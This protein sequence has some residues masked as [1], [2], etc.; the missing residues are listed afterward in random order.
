MKM[1]KNCFAFK[2]CKISVIRSFILFGLL[3]TAFN[4]GAQE[5]RIEI[6]NGDVSE[7]GSVPGSFAVRSDVPLGLPILVNYTVTGTAS[8]SDDYTQLP[9]L[10]IMP[11]GA[12][13]VPINVNGIID[14]SLIEGDE[15]ITVTITAGGGYTVAPDVNDNTKTLFIEDND[16]GIVSLSLTSPYDPDAAE[17]G[18]DQGQFRISLSAPNNTQAPVTVNYTISGSATNGVD[19][20]LTNAV[21]LSF[22]NN[23]V[24]VNRNIIVVPVDDPIAEDDETV[25]LTLN[26]TDSPSFTIGATSQATVTIADDD[27]NA[28]SQAPVLNN[29]PTAFCDAFSIA[30]DTYYSGS[31]STRGQPRLEY[32]LRSG[33]ICRLAQQ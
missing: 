11:A 28:G 25:I 27:C 23:G 3:F 8:P 12:T 15:S 24:Q 4:G 29:N 20:N 22:A 33:C 13:E 16:F 7:Q 9:G 32:E 18:P 14:D 26:S 19:Y 6:V 30:L 17:A 31:G 10:V 5:L 1:K 2:E 21:V